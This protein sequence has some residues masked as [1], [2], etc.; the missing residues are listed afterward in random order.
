MVTDVLFNRFENKNKFG[1]HSLPF[2]G[3]SHKMNQWKGEKGN[4]QESLF[5]F[6]YKRGGD[7]SPSLWEDYF[8]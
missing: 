8:I 2:G 5:Y 1:C 7:I 6:K 3:F 4:R